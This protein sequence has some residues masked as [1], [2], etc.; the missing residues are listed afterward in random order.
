MCYKVFQAALS[1]D[2]SI[3]IENTVKMSLTL[4]NKD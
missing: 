4:P 2:T 3:F 1:Q